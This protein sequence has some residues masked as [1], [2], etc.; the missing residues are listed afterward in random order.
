MRKIIVFFFLWISIF[1]SA[2]NTPKENDSIP[3]KQSPFQTGFYPVGFFDLDMRFFVKYNNYEGM[4]LGLGG[5]TNQKLFKKVRIGGYIV[6]GFK[7]KRLKFKIG[8]GVRLN[9]NNKT[10]LNVYYTDD[11]SEMGSFSQLTDKLVYTLFEPRLVNITQFYKHKT[12]QTNLQHKFGKKVLSEFRL[13][14]SEVKQILNYQF[15]ANNTSFNQYTISEATASVR[16]SPKTNSFISEDGVLETYDGLPNISLQVVQGVKG[17]FKSNFNFTKLGLKLDYL[18]KREDLSST[19]LLLAGY[20]AFGD[21]PLT[22]LFHASPNSPTKD[23][24][25]QRFSVAGLQSFETMYFGEF[26]SDRLATF[27]VKHILRHF[28]ISNRIK[29]ELAFISRHALGDLKS[30]TQHQGL[31]FNTLN[32]IYNESG[33]EF[34]KIFYGFGFNFSYRYGFYHLPDFE[35]NISFKFTFYLKL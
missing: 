1:A 8:G 21:V 27:H 31:D 34:N 6:H 18:I 19:Q 20:T 35:D 7:D 16:F 9:T 29:P 23:E 4:R 14:R 2:Q 12:W 15:V 26:F 33:I 3:Q 10:W 28:K 24:I 17:I 22:H 5:L 25:L 13:S 30:K 11:I 32:Q